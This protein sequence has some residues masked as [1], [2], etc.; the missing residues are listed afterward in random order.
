M[1]PTDRADHVARVDPRVTR[2]RAGVLAAARAELIEAGYSGTTVDSVA[3][4]AGVARTTIYRHWPTLAQLVVDA[5]ADARLDPPVTCST[6]LVADLRTHLR[7]LRDALQNTAWGRM[8]PSLVDGASRDHELAELQASWCGVRRG[9]AI[10]CVQAALARGELT[11]ETDPEAVVDQLAGPLFYRHLMIRQPIDQ[12]YVD[13]LIAAVIKA[14]SPCPES[15][16][17]PPDPNR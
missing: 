15:V 16:A 6:D 2:T 4:R 13:Q 10:D 3:K 7:W 11:D 5:F 17:T 9:R 12:R 1:L 8:L 14:H